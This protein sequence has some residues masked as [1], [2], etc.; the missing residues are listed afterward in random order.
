MNTKNHNSKCPVCSKDSTAVEMKFNKCDIVK[1]NYCTHTFSQNMQI[2]SDEIYSAAYFVSSHKNFFSYPDLKL[3]AEI[4]Q[5]IDNGKAKEAKIIDL[6]CGTGNF[7]KYMSTFN[8]K[9]L[10]G[11]DLIKNEDG[12]I[13]Y[14]QGDILNY[15][16]TEKYDVVISNMNIE[17]IDDVS[18]YIKVIDSILEKDG[19]III[20][21]INEHSLIY[22]LSKI[23]YKLNIK[24]VARRLYDYHHVN[25]FSVKSLQLLLNNFGY[26]S[27]HLIL[28]SYPI[29]SVD[30]DSGLIGFFYKFIILTIFV[31]SN[32]TNSGI[33]QTQ[34]FRKEK[35]I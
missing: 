25:H 27:K 9:K 31:I 13:S 32:L 29:K 35:N 28:K 26:Q 21:T 7:L 12:I 11:I 15:N 1:C 14:F 16:Y 4:K 18:N 5:F 23:L 3:Y 20:N 2:T 19:I 22:N 6:G 17:H 34:F 24:F 33:S 30:I 8:Y 10:T